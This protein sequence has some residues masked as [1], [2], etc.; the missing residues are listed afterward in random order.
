ML[1]ALDGFGQIGDFNLEEIIEQYKTNLDDAE[2]INDCGHVLDGP[3]YMMKTFENKSLDAAL[4][5][6]AIDTDEIGKQIYEDI[7]ETSKVVDDHWAMNDVAEVIKNLTD[8]MDSEHKKEF[9]L[10]ILDSEIVNA[11]TTYGGYIYITTGLIEFV[12]SYDELAFI[13]AHEI[14]HEVNLHTQRKITKLMLTSNLLTQMSA[15]NMIDIVVGLNTKFS[16]PFDQIDEYEAD[17]YGVLLAHKAGYDS[18]RF[19]D[20]FKKMEKYDDKSIFKKLSSTH[21]FAEHRISCLNK[22]ITD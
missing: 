1:M 20:F 5:F 12:D 17:K 18:S 3:L 13:L 4:Q 21:P 19:A 8:Q 10:K 11:Y 6:N 22:Y 9:K 7:I 16:A 14:G 2:D 15:E